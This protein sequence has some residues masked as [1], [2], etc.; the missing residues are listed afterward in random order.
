MLYNKKTLPLDEKG[1][2]FYLD[3][4]ADLLNAIQRVCQLC[5]SPLVTFT[6]QGR[7]P[8]QPQIIFSKLSLKGP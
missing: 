8:V 4:T 7:L 2:E 1:F 3:R 5:L 6:L